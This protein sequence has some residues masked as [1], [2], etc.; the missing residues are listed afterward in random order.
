MPV[1]LTAASVIQSDSGNLTLAGVDGS[2][3]NANLTIQGRGAVTLDSAATLGAGTL[4][5]SGAGRAR[6][7]L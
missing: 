3:A 4:T 7:Q 2:A 1:T 5:K 6:V